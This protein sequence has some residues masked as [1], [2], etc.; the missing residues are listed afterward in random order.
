MLRETR[1]TLDSASRSASY[2]QKLIPCP[3]LEP[4]RTTKTFLSYQILWLIHIIILLHSLTR[5]CGVVVSHPFSIR[6]A[7][8]SIP[9]ESIFYFRAIGA[10]QS[11]LWSRNGTAPPARLTSLRNPSSLPSDTECLVHDRKCDRTLSA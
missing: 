2:E 10:V 9:G 6:E 5:A 7:P 3:K 8:G 4:G 11:P 1:G